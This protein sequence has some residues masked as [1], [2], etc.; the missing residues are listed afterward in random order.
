MPID[1]TPPVPDPEDAEY[2]AVL[3]ITIESEEQ[4]TTRQLEFADRFERGEEVPH[5]LSFEHP[6]QL[7]KLFT[8]K[9][10]EIVRAIDAE[11]PESLR[12]LAERL[13]RSHTEVAKDVNILADYG[14]VY[15]RE[16]GRAKAPY[17]PYEEVR[18]EYD[19]LGDDSSHAPA[20]A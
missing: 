14:I 8:D 17:I 11:P 3:L 18:V 19:M 16:H 20:P 15:F 2:P 13:D 4:A 6:S 5:V 10:H 1:T 7:R 9:R 12:Q